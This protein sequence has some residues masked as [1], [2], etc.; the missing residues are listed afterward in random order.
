MSHI[1]TPEYQFRS[2]LDDVLYEFSVVAEEPDAA[3]LDQFARQYPMYA[4]AL[5]DLAVD[6][7]L[8]ALRRESEAL[9]A[10]PA[11]SPAV[12]RAM[13]RFNKLMESHGRV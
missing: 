7:A 8:D 12:S 11:M 5:T 2:W 4:A 1:N 10:E 9:T 6:I 13:S 3:L